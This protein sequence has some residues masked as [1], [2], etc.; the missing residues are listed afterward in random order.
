M[1]TIYQERMAAAMAAALAGNKPRGAENTPEMRLYL[2]KLMHLVPR[3]PKNGSVTKLELIQHVIDYIGDLQDTL[4][5]DSEPESPPQSPVDH[6]S[7][8][9]AFNPQPQYHGYG[10]QPI[11]YAQTSDSAMECDSFGDSNYANYP[12]GYQGFAGG[13]G[14][15]YNP[16]YDSGYSSSFGAGASFGH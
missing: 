2:E 8:S 16:T 13:F 4:E 1:N 11:Q 9:D 6:V 12:S 14:N 3:C 7:F 15:A 10:A 5:S